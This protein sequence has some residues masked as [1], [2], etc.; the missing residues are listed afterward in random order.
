MMAYLYS[1]SLKLVIDS[2]RNGFFRGVC[3]IDIHSLAEI[4]KDCWIYKELLQV[5]VKGGFSA[6]SLLQTSYILKCFRTSSFIVANLSLFLSNPSR[7]N[8]ALTWTSSTK[9]GVSLLKLR[10]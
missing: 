5:Y 2:S 7:K 10:K 8:F 4:G 3:S 9:L 6:F 1:L